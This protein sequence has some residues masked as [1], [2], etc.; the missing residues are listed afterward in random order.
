[1][2][3]LTHTSPVLLISSP[4]V[5][6]NEYCHRS[7]SSPLALDNV[8]WMSLPQLLTLWGMM[9][10]SLSKATCVLM[11][12]YISYLNDDSGILEEE[13]KRKKKNYQNIKKLAVELEKYYNIKK[14]V[15]SFPWIQK[16][17]PRNQF[18]T[19]VCSRVNFKRKTCLWIY[20]FYKNIQSF[21]A[22]LGQVKW[23]DYKIWVLWEISRSA[24]RPFALYK[25]REKMEYEATELWQFS[26]KTSGG[27][28]Q[29]LFIK[30]LID[31]I[32]VNRYF[33]RVLEK[34]W[35]S[36]ILTVSWTGLNWVSKVTTR[37]ITEKDVGQKRIIYF[38]SGE[39]LS[40]YKWNKVC[41]GF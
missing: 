39:S 40:T 26:K 22:Y 3:S 34:S 16:T 19:H 4:L 35:L 8:L 5:F 13:N 6:D 27:Q 31:S 18:E 37:N 11:T 10:H 20:L 2:P 17:G 1:M 30:F 7:T 36:L 9:K 32:S 23:S 41:P 15:N 21:S 14:A 12:C 29:A 25:G 38:S 24:F 33:K 28:S